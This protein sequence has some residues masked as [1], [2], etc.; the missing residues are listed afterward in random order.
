MH[1]LDG[2]ALSKLIVEDLNKRVGAISGEI[3]RV[4]GLG[5]ILVGDNPASHTY[6]SNKEKSAKAAGFE[7]F[8]LRLPA[9]ATEEDVK[10]AI[11]DFNEDKRVDGILLQLPLP[12]HLKSDV[13][14]DLISPKKDADGLHPLNQGLLVRGDGIIHPCTP[15][16]V[17]RMID[18]AYDSSANEQVWLSPPADLGG[19]RAIVIG[20]SILVGKPM[21]T[22]LLQ[23]NATVTMAHSKTNDL[24]GLCATCDIIVAA[25]GVPKLVKGTWVKKG[26]VVIDVGINRG[27]DGKLVGDVD[28]ESAKAQAS[29]IT[30]VPGGVGP[31]TIAMLL[32]NTYKIYASSDGR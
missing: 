10:R 29:S 32:E 8:D 28:F 27:E 23:R 7:T 21:G 4:P 12:K 9:D 30:P 1:I 18:L 19:K 31:M 26:A 11:L 2:K 5:V 13:L 6:V 16:G 15:A 17:M 14:L 3:G 24:A 25:V 22:L 20:R